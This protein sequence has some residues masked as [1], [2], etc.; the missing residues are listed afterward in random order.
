M[1]FH[2]ILMRLS[3]SI[4]LSA[5][6]FNGPELFLALYSKK[7]RIVYFVESLRESPSAK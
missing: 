4:S 2:L 6:P 3:W 1:G 5:G 7:Y